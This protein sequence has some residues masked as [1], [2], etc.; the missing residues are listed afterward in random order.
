MWVVWRAGRCR[1]V[2]KLL[3]PTQGPI[4]AKLEPPKHAKQRAQADGVIEKPQDGAS[5]VLRVLGRLGAGALRPVWLQNAVY[6]AQNP[7]PPKKNGP[8]PTSTALPF[9]SLLLYPHPP[10]AASEIPLPTPEEWGERFGV[11]VLV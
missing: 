1:I 2:G 4:A 5:A 7:P 8:I 11:W 3:I 10:P 6:N 9:S